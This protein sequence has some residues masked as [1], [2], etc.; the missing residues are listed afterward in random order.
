VDATIFL[1]ASQVVSC[2]GP[3]RARRGTEMS[4]LETLTSAA[5]VVI[6]EQIAEVGP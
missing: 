6:G 2:A 4:Q 3:A 1:N 5:V